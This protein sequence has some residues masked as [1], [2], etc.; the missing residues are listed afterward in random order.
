MR[1]L[2]VPAACLAALSLLGAAR[3]A[4]APAP[5][6]SDAE[7]LATVQESNKR[8]RRVVLDN[9]LVVLLKA[10]P[11]AP[12]VSLQVWVASGSIH[13]QEYLG[14]GL[15]HAVEHMI[16][17]GTPTRPAGDIARAIEQMG[18]DINA[19]TTHDRTVFHTD[20]PARHWR[21]ALDVLC[22][23]VLHPAFPAD[24]WT[25]EKD[26]ILREMSMVH[27]D[28]DRLLNEQMW[29][30]AFTAHPY[31]HP[32][33]GYA[34]LFRAMTRDDLAGFYARRYGPDNATV[35]L[36]GDVDEAQAEAALRQAWSAWPRARHAPVWVPP[37]PAQRGER[38]VRLT[39]PNK[40]TRLHLVYHT[41]GLSHP[42]G[43]ALDLLAAVVGQGRSARLTQELKEKRRLV[44]SI[45]AWSFTPQDPGLFGISATLDP[46]REAEA[47]AAIRAEVAAWPR[48]AFR[49]DELDRVRRQMLVDELSGLQTM[50]GQARTYASGE[51]FAA[52]PLFSEIYLRSLA[53][54]TT[55]DVQAVAARYLRPDNLTV[56]VLSPDG[57]AASG[58]TPPATLR[59]SPVTLLPQD[60]GVRVVFREDHRLPFVWL[61][62]VFQGGLLSE[63]EADTGITRLM[64]ELLNRGA[65]GRSAAETARAVEQLGASLG[66]F[67]GYN[68]LGLTGR[69][70]AGDLDAFAPIFF[71]CLRAPTFPDEEIEKQKAVQLAELEQQYESPVFVAQEALGRLIFPN[72]P[73]RWSP[74]GTR[75]SVQSITPAHVRAHY[76]RL[77]VSGNLVLAVF[78]DLTPEAARAL[79]ERPLRALARD[80]APAR[81]HPL[82]QPALPA[83]TQQTQ[84][85]EQAI[86]LLGFPG[87]D[88]A[89]PRRDSLE[90]LE[91]ALSG[92]SSRLYAEIRE[93]RG[94]AY[95]TGASLRL[96]VDPGWFMLYA[97]TQPA[98][99]AEVESL[100]TAEL[101]RVRREG[102]S[103][104]EFQR[105]RNQ[106]LAEH[107]KRLQDN[108]Q[109]AMT[110][111]LDALYGLGAG[112]EFTRPARL[113]ALTRETVREAAGTLFGTNR[114]AV[115][116]VVPAAEKK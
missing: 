71:D 62:A 54:V 46:A 51:L 57:D 10:D 109:L 32:V 113:E 37:E 26:V 40:V 4:P 106:L 49:A 29:A 77:A 35:V 61:C 21:E 72:H 87:V 90:V 82:P 9:G 34:D 50:G 86:V 44:H 39:G 6:R 1:R 19:Y 58:A 27:D 97:G 8:L 92:Q 64:A 25:R 110:C 99:V 68:S 11:V 65:A 5:A 75:A 103:D 79:V 47:L 31:R 60:S 91:S 42:D 28:P 105:A 102:L 17:K 38:S 85:K 36:V 95:Y 84:P 52:N 63:T 55:A 43:P 76:R 3:A 74:L 18:G 96:G 78:G 23:A 59:A 66:P 48:A 115:S 30:T 73:Y 88:L 56:A 116:I 53:G 108:G 12:V 100:M 67:S 69:C 83:R 114:M 111:A 22:D 101:A 98:A 45:E 33:I 80:M 93:K 70:L 81:Q 2:H 24:E 41:V 107:E 89:D 20:V 16:F 14:S 13:E 15:S 112:H 7:A 104:A 94:L